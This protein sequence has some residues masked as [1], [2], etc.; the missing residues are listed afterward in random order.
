MKEF[1]TIPRPEYFVVVDLEATCSE[2]NQI[3]REK[4]ETIEIGAVML[5]TKKLTA[6]DEFQSFVKPI[7]FPVLTEFCKEL[8]TIQQNDIDGAELFPTVASQLREWLESYPGALFSSWG[9]Y[10]RYQFEGDCQLHG[11]EAPFG[12]GHLNI[13]KLFAARRKLKR[14][15]GMK[16]ALEMEG[17]E[18]TGTHHRGIDDARNITLLL[19][20]LIEENRVSEKSS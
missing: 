10:D 17:L 3:A 13:K 6:V 9:D 14:S 18:A 2:G 20:R 5:E 11:I 8:T 1:P 16:A 15:V 12:E 19:K 4:M 7:R